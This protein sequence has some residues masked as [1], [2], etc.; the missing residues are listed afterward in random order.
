MTGIG[1]RGRGGPAV[2]IPW[3]PAR[4]A[5]AR[6]GGDWSSAACPGHRVWRRDDTASGHRGLDARGKRRWR[7]TAYPRVR[8]AQVAE[9]LDPKPRESQHP[10]P[11]QEQ[12]ADRTAH[13]PQHPPAAARLVDE[14]VWRKTAHA[15]PNPITV[16]S[17]RSRQDNNTGIHLV[18]RGL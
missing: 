2:E 11:N 10:K 3:V 18:G 17:T 5:R 8:D 16:G 9:R 12:H 14:D 6:S 13:K 1:V 7:G 4:F 15:F